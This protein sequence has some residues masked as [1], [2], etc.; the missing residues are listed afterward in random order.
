M[1]TIGLIG[2]MSWESSSIYY[3]LVNEWTRHELGGSHSA[4]CIM[5]SPDFAEIEALQHAGEWQKLGDKVV[6]LA[7]QLE[8][9]GADFIVLCTNT[10]H[11]FAPQIIDNINIDFLHIVDPTVQAIKK[12]GLQNINGDGSQTV[13]LL[14]TRFTME[15]DFYKGRLEQI[16]GLQVLVPDAQDRETVHNI[17]YNELVRG[18]IKDESRSICHGII[19]KLAQ[20]GAQA[21]ILGC[22]ELIM[23]IR[24]ETC[25]E[26]LFDTTILHT[27]AAVTKALS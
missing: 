8:A 21:I 23:L 16:P 11:R 17:I 6:G 5:V 26:L 10:M 7:K 15:Q 12:F 27:Q 20:D 3:R 13:G 25:P 1:K 4:N 18:Q 14:G 9:A 19:E 2:G 22:T 24:Q